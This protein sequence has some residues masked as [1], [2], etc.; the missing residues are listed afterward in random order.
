MGALTIKPLA[1]KVRS[2]E[3][4]NIEIINYL[5][6]YCG[7]IAIQKRGN[8]IIRI[9]PSRKDSYYWITDQMRFFFEGLRKQRIEYPLLLLKTKYIKITWQISMLFI[10]YIKVILNIMDILNSIERRAKTKRV[11]IWKNVLM[12]QAQ[13]VEDLSSNL[14]INEI[15]LTR[16]ISR[17]TEKVYKG[18]ISKNFY[19]TDILKS[20]KLI[21][22]HLLYNI[23]IINDYP[24]L[25]TQI[26]KERIISVGKNLKFYTYIINNTNEELKNIE[27]AKTLLGFFQ[28]KII[29][30][31]EREIENKKYM[32]IILNKNP[33]ALNNKWINKTVGVGFRLK[34]ALIW[35]LGRNTNNR[36][37]GLNIT[38]ATHGKGNVDKG[39]YQIILP[40]TTFMEEDG[41][42]F[43]PF[44]IIN[45]TRLGKIREAGMRSSAQLLYIVNFILNNKNKGNK[46]KTT[47]ELKYLKDI[48]TL[49]YGVICQK[50]KEMAEFLTT[51]KKKRDKKKS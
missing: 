38:F 49:K 5:D 47:I 18:N 39:A 6:S 20:M 45:G 41:F 22:N 25:W 12:E 42:R 36:M 21:K 46:S 19:A 26:K 24:R 3:I 44:G 16:N 28:N 27:K 50:L 40:I 4:N 48:L 23:N 31:T 8:E 34:N 37:R 35:N 29:V 33:A 43:N 11:K 30:Y 13:G 2:W 32:Q 17:Y 51:P 1:F 10:K 14:L 15:L 7:Q 9:L